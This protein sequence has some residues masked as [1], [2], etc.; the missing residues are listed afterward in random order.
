MIKNKL[1]RRLKQSAA[2]LLAGAMVLTGVPLGNITSQAAGLLPNT[3][4]QPGTNHSNKYISNVSGFSYGSSDSTAFVFG[5]SSGHQGTNSGA[6]D[7]YTFN[8]AGVTESSTRENNTRGY[9]DNAQAATLAGTAANAPTIRSAY[10]NNW[11]HGY[12]AFGKPYRIGTDVQNTTGGSPY[13]TTHPL[14]PVVSIW[15]GDEPSSASSTTT[16][17]KPLHT[18]SG[19]ENGE[20][21]TLTEG[22]QQVQLRQE[23]K[24]SDDDQ[25]VVVQYTVYNP[26][27]STVDF[28]VGNETDTMVTSQDA[29]PIFVTPHEAGGLF[30][31]V[32]FQ[33]STGGQYGLTVFD[34]YTSGKGAGITKDRKSVV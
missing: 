23:I 14:D 8:F 4:L 17:I 6:G 11:W 31:G 21:M 25:Y 22:T 30:E 16:A 20:V 28:M 5:P 27:T 18:G 7:T 34:I 33:N 19:H 1:I 26:G 2:G 29:V 32:H 12:Y 9:Y 15:S 24:P 13:E 3:D 10:S